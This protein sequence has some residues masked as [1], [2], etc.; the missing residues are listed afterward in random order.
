MGIFFDGK[1]EDIA[2]GGYRDDADPESNLTKKGLRDLR[3][4][5]MRI[6]V[7]YFSF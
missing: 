4:G 5:T 7:L 3:F 1:L 2:D 6:N